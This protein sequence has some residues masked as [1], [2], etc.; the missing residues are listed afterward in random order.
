M[1]YDLVVDEDTGILQARF[2]GPGNVSEAWKGV[3][4]IRT[5]VANAPVDGILVDVRDSTYT[6]SADEARNFAI[7]FVSFLG[8]RRLAFVTR[9]PVHYVVAGSVAQ[10]AVSRGVDAR[11]FHEHVV[12]A[13]AWLQSADGA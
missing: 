7:E 5:R 2:F 12:E 3:A 10:Q 11:V 6:P 9:L 1:P 13:V 4:A 8:R